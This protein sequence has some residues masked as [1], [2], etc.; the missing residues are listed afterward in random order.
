MITKVLGMYAQSLGSRQERPGNAQGVLEVACFMLRI[1]GL[2]VP[3][4]GL[5]NRS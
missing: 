4:G 3:L 1:I 5:K 2:T